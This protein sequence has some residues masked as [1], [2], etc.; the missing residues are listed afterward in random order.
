MADAINGANTAWMI[1]A[2]ALVLFMTLPGLALFYGG[3]VRSK[4]VLSIFVQCFALA[5]VMS[6]LWVLYGYSLAFGNG[7]QWQW[8]IG[9]LDK[10]LLKGVTVDSVSGTI[11]ESLFLAFQ[12]TFAIITPALVVGAFAERMKFKSMLLFSI[13][14]FTLSYLPICHM[15]WAGEGALFHS[16]G[17]LDFAGGTVVHVNAGIAG[18]VTCLMIGRRSGYPREVMR[19]HN[20]PFAVMGAGML[21]V[22]W[23][24]FNAG[25]E[26]AAD[27]TAAMALLVTHLAAATAAV[28]WMLIEMWAH[29]KASALGI[30]TGAVAGLV[31]ITPASGTAGPL[32][33]IVIGAASAVAGYYF[34]TKVKHRFGYDDSLDVFGVHGVG[35]I[36]GALL[37]GVFA[38]TEFGGAGLAEGVTVAGQV[39]AQAK[40]LLVTAAW[41]GVVSIA[42]FIIVDR[43]IGMRVPME[44]ER[45]GLD[46]AE[47]QEQAYEIV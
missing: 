30:A 31:A 37:T 16:W 22:G 23:F 12:M 40:S 34:A 39:W 18:L 27:G 2:T 28:V 29:G 10:A 33:A 15:A 14:W 45:G 20:L 19:P 9:S 35:G 7:G 21:W 36:V 42:A 8:V 43:L 25:S 46:L 32:G 17:V 41:S 5:G 24:G 1:V 26:L 47:H 13:I 11:P 44:V 4:N 6:L 38:A 3:L